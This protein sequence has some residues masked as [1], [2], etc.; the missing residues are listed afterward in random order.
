MQ[1]QARAM[2]DQPTAEWLAQFLDGLGEAEF[3]G[4]VQITVD[5]NRGGVSRLQ[6][7]EVKFMA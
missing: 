5:F 4:R 6:A 3:T 1:T 7:A 2:K